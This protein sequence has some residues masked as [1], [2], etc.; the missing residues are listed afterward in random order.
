MTTKLRT[1]IVDDEIIWR[2]S[3]ADFL[4][5]NCEQDI[6]LIGVAGTLESALLLIEREKPDLVFLDVMLY[7]KTSF[8]ILEIT[9]FKPPAVVF[10]TGFGKEFAIDALHFQACDYLM[11]PIELTDLKMSIRKAHEMMAK[12]GTPDNIQLDFMPFP[13]ANDKGFDFVPFEEIIFIRADKGLLAFYLL[14]HQTRKTVFYQLQQLERKLAVK[15]FFRTHNSYIVN[16]NHMKKITPKGKGAQLEM[17][18]S[19][20]IPVSQKYLK[21][22]MQLLEIGGSL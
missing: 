8:Q 19:H 9:A 4:I 5:R 20:T 12:K 6:D 17:T 10:I 22:L 3:F 15:S 7:Q 18:E 14:N 11:K 21:K 13:H 2:D 1:I 16:L